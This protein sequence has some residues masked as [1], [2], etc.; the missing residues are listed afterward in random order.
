MEP[1]GAGAPER[2][3]DVSETWLWETYPEAFRK[4]LRDHTT[5]RNIIWAT[6]SY[7]DRG[8][9]YGFHDEITPERVIGPNGQLIRPRALK[10]RDEQL[11]RVKQKAEVFTPA[12]ICNAQNNLIDEVWFGRPDAFNRELTLPDGSHSWV[13]TQGKVEFP[14]GKS[15][16]D[17]VRDTR[18]EITC[19]EAPYLVSRHDAVSGQMISELSMRVGLLDRKLRVVSENTQT[20]GE[21]LRWAKTAL[22]S[23]YGY[24]WQG[25][26]LL[27]AREALFMTVFEY[28]EAKFGRPLPRKSF[29]GVAYIISWNLWQMDGLRFVVPGSC[30]TKYEDEV[31]PTIDFGDSGPS[32]ESEPP[33]RTKKE[34]P[35][36]RKGNGGRMLD[37]LAE[38]IGDPALICDWGRFHTLTKEQRRQDRCLYAVTFRSLIMK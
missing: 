34:C 14:E 32:D 22:E 3:V 29:D 26:N 30:D 1:S 28:Y 7:L 35:A 4:L 37:R 36:C 20:S 24:E 17:Y 19:G 21:W 8:P 5:G 13:P 16:R 25:D 11:R 31:D 12:W 10:D 9:G 27:L 38:H 6:D 15:W 2:K 18:L 33:V 23:T